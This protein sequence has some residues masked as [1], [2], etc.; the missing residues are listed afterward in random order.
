[1][2]RAGISTG[3]HAEKV[4]P[5]LWIQVSMELRHTGSCLICSEGI[6]VIPAGKDRN[7]VTIIT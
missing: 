6:N 2:G 7:A 5:F 4:A 3:W 1:M